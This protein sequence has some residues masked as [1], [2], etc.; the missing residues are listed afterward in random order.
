MK[1]LANGEMKGAPLMRLTLSWAFV[2][3]G[4]CG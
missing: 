3:L 1:Y 4:D 2:F